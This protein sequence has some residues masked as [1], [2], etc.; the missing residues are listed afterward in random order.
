MCSQQYKKYK[1]YIT[2]II[3]IIV[4]S[5]CSGGSSSGG[6]GGRCRLVTISH[7]K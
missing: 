6:S 4:S 1:I 5:T 3:I 7:D 2:T